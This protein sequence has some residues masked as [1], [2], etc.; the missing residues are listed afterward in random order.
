M[1]VIEAEG[2]LL[3]AVGTGHV[4]RKA[5][6]T[7]QL[8]AKAARVVK[9][10]PEV[11][12]K[13]TSF[14]SLS[15]GGST[16]R[17]V[18]NFKTQVEYIARDGDLELETER[19]D[20]L[21][22]REELQELIRDWKDD[23]ASEKRHKNQRDTMHMVLSMP[24]GTP[25]EAVRE[26]ARDFARKAFKNHQYVFAL[27]TPFTDPDEHPSPNP[28]V[29]LIVK[30][31]AVDGSRLNP[32]KADLQ[33]WREEFAEAMR[34]QGVDA[35]A[36]PRTTR[37]VVRKRTKGVIASIE[38]VQPGREP[39]RARVNALQVKELAEELQAEKNGEIR[40]PQ[41]T[42]EG[43]TKARE[44][45]ASR[46]EAWRVAA[47][48]LEARAVGSVERRNERPN[49]DSIDQERARAG[50]LA[51]AVYQSRLER[52]RRKAPAV[53]VARMRD[54][55][56]LNV[57][58]HER[59]AQVFLQSH[60]HD[61]VGQRG[62]AD[63]DV[64]RARAGFAGPGEGPAGRAGLPKR[65]TEAV[66]DVLNDRQ[67]ADAVRRLVDGMPAFV[68]KREQLREQ[69]IKDFSKKGRSVETTQAKSPETRAL[70]G[71]LAP[72]GP[73]PDIER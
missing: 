49:Y 21:K 18:A 70:D 23:F 51:A 39:R 45:H 43:V 8:R 6:R 10:T 47:D 60:A 63:H 54:V 26:A 13:I 36:T 24:E 5:N 22:G 14:G 37:G 19:G 9:H 29:H 52:D 64:R 57:V 1:A 58:Q 38:R 46:R 25:D 32:R 15:G 69:L 59:P 55:S 62:A 3:E 31:R 40:P 61:R 28:H 68:T 4:R 66:R 73:A 50:Q 30:M 42:P 12:V 17:N 20:V 65:V 34:D 27:H 72:G 44:K 67:L 56:R 71:A 7:G 48:E 53:A 2:A 11:M 16:G 33:D 41:P 35:E